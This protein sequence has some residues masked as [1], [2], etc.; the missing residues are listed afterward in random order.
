MNNDDPLFNVDYWSVLY[1]GA[2]A[3]LAVSFGPIVVSDTGAAGTVIGAGTQ[4][5]DVYGTTGPLTINP[6]GVAFAGVGVR[7]GQAGNMQA[8]LGEVDILSNASPL[9]FTN[10]NFNDSTDSARRTI[11]LASDCQRQHA[12]Q[13]HGARD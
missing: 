2:D 9:A 8:I 13:R 3:H 1:K 11:H 12:H 5:V 4:A 7:L 6:S 10:V